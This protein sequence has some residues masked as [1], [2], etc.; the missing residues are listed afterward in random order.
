MLVAAELLIGTTLQVKEIAVLVGYSGTNDAFFKAF[1]AWSKM[2]PTAYRRAYGDDHYELGSRL[3]QGVQF[4]KVLRA[5]DEDRM[6]CDFPSALDGLEEASAIVRDVQ[7]KDLSARLG[8]ARHQQAAHYTRTADVDLAFDELTAAARA[9]A[10]AGDLPAAIVKERRRLAVDPD[11]D[12]VLLSCL[13]PDCRERLVAEEGA[14]VREH[15]RH[16]LYLV[17]RDLPWFVSCCD[18]CYR[19]V[20]KAF[21]LARLGLMNDAWKAWWLAAHTD[22]EDR[23]TPPSR[24]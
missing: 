18:D 1:R 3:E 2:T 10:D 20:W 8:L 24:G 7:I 21:G 9:Y 12:Q 16:A 22:L 14:A 17:R 15:L 4:V 19:V 13:C 23:A 5:V 11:T 6:A